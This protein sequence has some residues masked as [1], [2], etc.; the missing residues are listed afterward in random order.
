MAEDSSSNTAIV[1]IVILV[2][3]AL[4]F[5]YFIFVRNAGDDANLEI[6]IGGI[7]GVVPDSGVDP[8]PVKLPHTEAVAA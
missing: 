8:L 5:A 4:A 1:A 7:G 6:D 3:V 2:I